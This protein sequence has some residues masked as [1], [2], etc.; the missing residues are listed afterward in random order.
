MD[1][2]DYIHGAP[3]QQGLT[4]ESHSLSS[5]D[6]DLG[7]SHGTPYENGNGYF[8]EPT[9]D[10]NGASS[11]HLAQPLASNELVH[12]TAGN[13]NTS[14]ISLP[15]LE[16]SSEEISDTHLEPNEPVHF[17]A[18]SPNDSQTS[19]PMLEECT[20][21][22]DEIS[23]APVT[24]TSAGDESATT[25]PRIH[26]PASDESSRNAAGGPN[27][28]PTLVASPETSPDGLP[29]VHRIYTP[30]FRSWERLDI[31]VHIGLYRDKKPLKAFE[32]IMEAEVG[33]RFEKRLATV[34]TE[35]RDPS[36]GPAATLTL[37]GR[38]RAPNALVNV[39]DEI[40]IL[41]KE[42]ETLRREI[43]DEMGISH[44]ITSSMFWWFTDATTL[45]L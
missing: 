24:P 22:S 33:R 32:L 44:V 45:P 29:I 16:G 30:T 42:M 25:T 23:D 38:P 36:E 2:S 5:Y 19:L 3:S 4:E 21:A 43:G 37:D 1:H 12:S 17:A 34:P 14:Q 40:R 11:N 41:Q 39:L 27:F 6:E 28:A 9:Y 7:Y 15:I 26:S 20:Y 13:A 35:S 10:T 18:G 8:S 31:S